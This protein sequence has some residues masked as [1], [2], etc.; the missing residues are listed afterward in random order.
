[1]RRYASTY[2]DPAVLQT[3]GAGAIFV[4]VPD[5][6]PVPWRVEIRATR[7]FSLC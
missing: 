1:M 3:S 4:A 7:R 5:R 2:L 6:S